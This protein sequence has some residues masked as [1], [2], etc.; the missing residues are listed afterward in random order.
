MEIDQQDAKFAVSVFYASATNEI[1]SKSV[2][3][4][5]P[6]TVTEVIALSGFEQ[7]FPNINWQD[8]GVGLFGRICSPEERVSAGARI[9]IYRPLTFDPM[10]S[11]RRRATH[12]KAQALAKKQSRV[13]HKRHDRVKPTSTLEQSTE[14]SHG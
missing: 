12:R 4:S 3:L 10:Q 13:K 9:E 14:K 11:R 2:Y 6:T 5:Q 1:W 7:T 8:A